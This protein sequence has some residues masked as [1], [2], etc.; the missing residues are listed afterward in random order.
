MCVGGDSFVVIVLF[1]RGAKS[2][3]QA[4]DL[5]PA[6]PLGWPLGIQAFGELGEAVEGAPGS[7]AVGAG[8]VVGLPMA[9]Q[10]GVEAAGVL[11]VELEGGAVGQGNVEVCSNEEA[12][13]ILAAIGSLQRYYS[14]VVPVGNVGCIPTRP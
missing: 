3:W 12:H 7:Q 14:R 11:L 2:N 10:L 1:L 4:L 5:R 13:S 8:R 9:R 6:D